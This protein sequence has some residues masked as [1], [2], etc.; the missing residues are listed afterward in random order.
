MI[1]LGQFSVPRLVLFEQSTFAP[2]VAASPNT[3]QGWAN[4]EY[5]V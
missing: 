3:I 2:L 5:A 1:R 4:P